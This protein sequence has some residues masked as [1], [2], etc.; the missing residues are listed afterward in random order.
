MWKSFFVHLYAAPWS[1]YY[2][3]VTFPAVAAVGLME[4]RLTV[5]VYL[6]MEPNSESAFRLDGER[7]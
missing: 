6:Q 2:E 5:I 7:L 4:H 3:E 1:E